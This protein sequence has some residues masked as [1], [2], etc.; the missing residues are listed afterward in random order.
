MTQ[1][2]LEVHIRE[3]RGKGYRNK[4]HDEGLIPAVVYGKAV[5]NI[6]VEVDARELE[7]ILQSGRNTLVN[8]KVTGNGGGSPYKVIVKEVQTDPLRHRILHADFQQ[9]SMHDRIDTTVPVHLV[10]ESEGVAAG[11]ILQQLVREVEISCLPTEI[12]ESLTVNIAGMKT[13]DS[14]TVADLLM[15]AGVQLRTDP[16][17]VV[18]SVLAPRIA[19]TV[20]EVEKAGNAATAEEDTKEKEA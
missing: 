13:G 2:N 10:G 7:K 20:D 1:N 14:L 8:L 11:G 18:A 6:P 4:I 9:I 19:D 12:P 3:S 5:G 17:T 16:G 15:P